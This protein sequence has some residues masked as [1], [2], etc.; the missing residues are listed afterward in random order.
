MKLARMEG[1]SF[2]TLFSEY[3]SEYVPCGFQDTEVQTEI[4]MCEACLSWLSTAQELREH[5]ELC[6]NR[7]W[8][9]GDEVYRCRR[10]RCVVFEIDGRKVA[11]IPYS[12]RIARIAKHFLEEKTTLDDLHFFAFIALF[13]VDDYGYHFVGYFS[14]EWRKSM[15]CKNSLSCVM[16]LPPY[17][18]KGYG[19]LLIEISYEMGRAEGI[20]G[21]P[22]RPLS[23]SGKRVFNRI[24]QEEL[25]QAVASLN[26]KGLPL[27]LNSLSWES[28]MTIEDVAVALHQLNAVFFVTKNRPLLHLPSGVIAL[29]KRG[30]KLNI[31]SFMWT[32]LH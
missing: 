16:V 19:T 18:H 11:S 32:S 8:I 21:S 2:K 26:E 12:R 7:F 10:R 6:P 4:F 25:L 27:T 28:G 23:A 17:R 15:N 20:P 13:E 31:K 24:W 29:A 9:P 30:R 3:A 5:I 1:V 22:E 14:K